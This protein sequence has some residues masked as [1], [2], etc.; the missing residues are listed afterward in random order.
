M[1][2][3]SDKKNNKQ[4]FSSVIKVWDIESKTCLQTL[5]VGHK[6]A[7]FKISNVKIA[8]S[9]CDGIIIIWNIYNGNTL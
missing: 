8:S 5:N 2:V 4:Q 6:I 1:R 7:L 9:D 3:I